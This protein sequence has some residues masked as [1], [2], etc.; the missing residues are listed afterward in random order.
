MNQDAAVWSIEE[1]TQFIQQMSYPSVEQFVRKHP[2]LQ[3]SAL[4]G[5]SKQLPKDYA[6]RLARVLGKQVFAWQ[7][8]L[9]QLL[10]RW[11]QDHPA[12]CQAVQQ[13][14]PPLTLE[15]LQ[16]LIE[17][18]GG[19]EVCSALHTDPHAQDHWEVCTALKQGMERGEMSRVPTQL[20]PNGTPAQPGP[21]EEPTPASPDPTPA[22]ATRP[23]SEERRG[24]IGTAPPPPTHP[25]NGASTHLHT[26]ADY[27]HALEA[28]VQALAA[29]EQTVAACG[30]QLTQPATMRN[31]LAVQRAAEKLAAA[32]QKQYEGLGH[33]VALEG[34]VLALLRAEVQQAEAAGLVERLAGLLPAESAVATSDEARAHLQA[35]GQVRE[36]LSAAL[37]RHAERRA[38]LTKAPEVI[39]RLLRE[40]EGLEGETGPL[41]VSLAK[42]KG[43]IGERTG[44]QQPERTL[45]QAEV[46]QGRAIQL[47]DVNAQN[48][49]STLQRACQD[50]ELLLHQSLHLST[51]LPEVANLQHTIDGARALLALPLPLGS[52]NP[53]PFAPARIIAC[54]ATLR[55]QHDRLRQARQ[56]YNPQIAL[57]TL[58]AFEQQDISQPR[59][60]Q[61]RE[62]GAALVGAASLASGYAGL[63]WRVGS[64]LLMLLEN[65]AAEQFYERF[66]YA[67]VA[68]ALAASLREGDFPL[69]LSFADQYFYT[70][71]DIASIFAHPRVLESLSDVCTS[72]ASLHVASECFA[73]SSPAVRKA[74]AAF[75]ACAAEINLPAPLRLQVS[76]ALFAAAT[77]PEERLQAG[78]VLI[79]VL[80]SQ[81]QRVHAYF[82]WRA[83]AEEQPSL[84]SHPVGLGALYSL[85]WWLMLG[86]HT[87]TTQLA[88]L[89]SDGALQQ[90]GFFVP[91]MALAL[92]LGS[93]HLARANHPQ[94][95]E[96]TQ[97]YAEM[98]RDQ[99]YGE[100][101][102]ALLGRLPSH[103]EAAGTMPEAEQRASTITALTS[104]FTAALV[105]G[106]RRMEVSNYRFA[107][108]KQMRMQIDVRLKA[109]LVALQ[110]PGDLHDE[111]VQ[112]LLQ[113]EP[114][115][116]AK[117]L[118]EQ[119]ERERR[120]YG[121]GSIE[122][123]DLKKLRKDL[124]KVAAHLRV[125]ALKRA[126]LLALGVTLS[127][128]TPTP[129][130]AVQWR[131]KDEPLLIE[132][133]R[134]LADVPP[135]RPLLQHALPAFPWVMS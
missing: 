85:L 39:E 48:W 9:Q 86:S 21:A 83:L 57:A 34:A 62:I 102:D 22:V 75:L 73:Q 118:I 93:L 77:T 58:E 54:C 129:G 14:E 104:A 69:G 60:Q 24:K 65:A 82:V 98:L 19:Q 100:I 33:F 41:Q 112:G 78:L 29:I 127:E 63:I 8:V 92:C 13:L 70:G 35:I 123:D 43:M 59:P 67:A 26:V 81:E 105:E 2:P 68:T 55:Q 115:D 113:D 53:Q 108:T 7:Q 11:R 117:M 97:L 76:G 5:F 116:V 72:S 49:A 47:R 132:V 91:G 133:Q 121:Y 51:D 126:Q 40:I 122:G 44:D 99:H 131:P 64:R 124:E 107:P 125:A 25:T 30:Q 71:T 1:I 61:L 109:T 50:A 18:Y 119:E 17:R 52:P 12:V 56:A 128:P 111:L 79:Q 106:R 10:E 84:Y 16:P 114:E 37:A 4:A 94:G 23:K 90:T 28:Q 135:A 103:Q 95:E 110:Q 20:A 101:G 80:L 3:Q 42:L 46:I 89:C 15:L 36:H 66:G 120:Q 38:A 134:L 32:S 6:Q 96:L 45:K 74:A 27:V 87:P 31:P 130:E 88:L